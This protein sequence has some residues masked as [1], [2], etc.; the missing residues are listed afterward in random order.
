MPRGETCVLGYV[1]LLV[2]ISNFIEYIFL[3]SCG[4]FEDQSLICSSIVNG[5]VYSYNQ[6]NQISEALVNVINTVNGSYCRQRATEFL[7]NYYF[8]R[9]ENNANIVPICD[10]SCSEYLRTGICASDIVNLLNKL[11]D[12]SYPNI[13]VN[14]LLENNCS[15]PYDVTLSNSCANL[16]GKYGK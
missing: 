5:D 1:I 13:S 2:V 14:G 7:C 15:P 10:Q 12:E 11:N 8:P 6:P 9:C 4:R 16:T 3:Y